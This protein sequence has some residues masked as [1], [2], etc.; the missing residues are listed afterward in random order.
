MKSTLKSPLFGSVL[1]EPPDS[2]LRE[3]GPASCT[4]N[5][6]GVGAG[7]GGGV[8]GSSFEGA[9]SGR[10]V[11]AD[12][13][14]SQERAARHFAHVGC[15]QGHPCPGL[16]AAGSSLGSRGGEFWDEWGGW[17]RRQVPA[18][19]PHLGDG[20]V[21]SRVPLLLSP[22]TLWPRSAWA[23]GHSRAR[24]TVGKEESWTRA[25]TPCVSW[26]RSL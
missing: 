13:P 1:F 9:A 15:R 22:G 10:P 14:A 12:R 4:W 26:G 5:R 2:S 6:P 16:G 8:P 23:A 17:S 25:S 19:G 20:P 24:S 3:T 18:S 21:A 11:L 7:P